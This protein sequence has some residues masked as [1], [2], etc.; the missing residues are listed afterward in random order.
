MRNFNIKRELTQGQTQR[1]IKQRKKD[2]QS[3]AAKVLSINLGNTNYPIGSITFQAFEQS[4]TSATTAV[5][6]STGIKQYPVVGELVY[7]YPSTDDGGELLYS[8]PSNTQNTPTTNIVDTIYADQFIEREDINSLLPFNG[9]ILLEGRHGQSIRF[10]HFQDNQHAWRGTATIGNAVTF[11]SNGQ[12]TTED[13]LDLIVEDVNEDAAIIALAE[14]ASLDLIDNSKR[15]SYEEPIQN[16]STY[17][18]NQVIVASDRLYFNARQESILLSAQNANIGLS[19]NTLNL[20]GITSIRLDAPSYNLNTD[21]FNATNQQRSIDSEISTYN[22]TQFDLTGT[23]VNVNY[24]RIGLGENAAEPLLQ[25]TEFLT[26]IAALNSSLSQLATALTGV[27]ALLA[28]LP[29]GQVPAA[30]LQ[31]AATAVT[32]QANSI[33]TKAASGNYLSTT[34]FTK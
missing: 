13:G 31:T 1:P 20:D 25:S 19:A 2:T 9:D 8:L 27:T 21:S 10:S 24:N 18:G 30:T 14:G 29:G 26:D 12:R 28:A 5:P 4:N 15:D 33:Q 11:I 32:T 7:I 6:F 22:F 34:V 16:G 23:N 17:I 3:F